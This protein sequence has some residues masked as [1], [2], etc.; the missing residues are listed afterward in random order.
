MHANLTYNLCAGCDHG[1]DCA[2]L[3]VND[4]G[5]CTVQTFE[6]W[7]PHRGCD[8]RDCIQGCLL[9]LGCSA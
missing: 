9:A 7:A 5:T 4:S 6:A 8:Y 2:K 1:D 3:G